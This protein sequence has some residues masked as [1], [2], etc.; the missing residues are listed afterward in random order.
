M[1]LPA[2]NK[3][4]GISD[5]PPSVRFLNLLPIFSQAESQ[6]MFSNS[7][8]KFFTCGVFFKIDINSFIAFIPILTPDAIPLKVASTNLFSNKKSPNLTIISPALAVRSS[9]S[10]SSALS[11]MDKAVIANRIPPPNIVP[12]IFK[13][14]NKP[15]MV[16]LSLSAFSSDIIRPD[17]NLCNAAIALYKSRE[18]IG[19]K[20]SLHA[21]PAAPNTLHKASQTFL[22]EL[23]SSDLPSN[24]LISLSI[25]EI[26]IPVFFDCSSSCL[27][28]STSSFAKPACFSSASDICSNCSTVFV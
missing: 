14:V 18:E 10:I 23:R 12:P 27:R 21:F 28:A 6:S 19:S 5:K 22:N 13:R 7:L 1:F 20:V 11:T 26:G 9:I 3:L 25:S 24:K 16:R 17:V 8:T 2:S 15:F 4:L